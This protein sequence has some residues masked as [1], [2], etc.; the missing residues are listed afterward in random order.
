MIEA[1]QQI[2][3]AD[4]EEA[5][6]M[7]W[8]CGFAFQLRSKANKG[9]LRKLFLDVKPPGPWIDFEHCIDFDSFDKLD[10]R[11]HPDGHLRE[12]YYTQPLMVGKHL[13][14]TMSVTIKQPK[15]LEYK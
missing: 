15:R 8:D 6:W 13:E 4:R 10:Y 5:R 1:G 7:Y 2:G 14:D 11:R 9:T 3:P 12:G